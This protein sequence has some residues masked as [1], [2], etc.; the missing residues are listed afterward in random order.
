MASYRSP[1]SIARGALPGDG[2]A[3][4]GGHTRGL[5]RLRSAQ[6]ST[7]VVRVIFGFI[8]LVNAFYKWQPAFRRGFVGLI[9]A[10]AKGQ[11]SWL[12]PWFQAWHNLIALQPALFSYGVALAETFLGLALIAGFARKLIYAFGAGWSI[13][14]WTTAEGFGQQHG[15]PTDIGAAIIYAVVFVALLALDTGCGTRAMSVDALIERRLPWWRRI[16]E[17][18]S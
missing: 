2:I 7:S 14:I 5:V 13:V 10:A 4:P 9:T 8:W 18:R 11:P 1:R 15:V 3:R 12:M 17:V 16:A 6:R